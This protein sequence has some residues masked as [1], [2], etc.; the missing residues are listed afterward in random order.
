[1]EVAS[2]Q[3]EKLEGEL[4]ELKK[5][6]RR[7]GIQQESLI[8]DL[9]SKIDALPVAPVENTESFRPDSLMEVAES[10]FHL[11]EVLPFAGGG[12]E[13]LEAIA[14]VWEK[15]DLVCRERGLEI[16]RQSGVL[17]DSRKHE[18]IDRAPHGGNPVVTGVTAP[19]FIFNGR[20]LKPARVT[21]TE[22]IFTPG[23]AKGEELHGE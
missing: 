23:M 4:G 7:Q 19:G 14:M 5:L 8:R 21:L 12:C 9:T 1:M 11:G 18:A 6:V 10:F 17:F 15:L 13:T 3:G 22:T 2:A 16:V 20:V